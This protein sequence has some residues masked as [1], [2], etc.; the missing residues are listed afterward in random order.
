LEN[1]GVVQGYPD[2]SFGPDRKLTRAEMV[3]IVLV[4]RYGSDFS[5]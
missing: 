3:K 1:H 2:G 5:T 4:A